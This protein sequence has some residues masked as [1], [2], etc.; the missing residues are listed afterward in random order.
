L[1]SERTRC[2]AVEAISACSAGAAPQGATTKRPDGDLGRVGVK[3]DRRPHQE[4]AALAGRARLVHRAPGPLPALAVT[5]AG[6]VGL[7]LRGAISIQGKRDQG[8]VTSAQKGTDC[9]H[10]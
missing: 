7:D 10:L 8:R 9:I 5:L 6:V 4:S 1:A 2:R 3:G